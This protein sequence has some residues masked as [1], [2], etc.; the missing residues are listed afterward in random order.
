VLELQKIAAPKSAKY[1]SKVRCNGSLKV[2]SNIKRCVGEPPYVRA[3]KT[4]TEKIERQASNQCHKFEY[5]TLL[6]TF[7]DA[8]TRDERGIDEYN[9]REVVEPIPPDER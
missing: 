9:L 2:L 5:L 6:N 4:P 8:K 1:P 7:P 3:S